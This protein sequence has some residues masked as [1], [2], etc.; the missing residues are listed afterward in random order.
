MRAVAALCPNLGK[1]SKKVAGRI[2]ELPIIK[3]VRGP[4]ATLTT[5]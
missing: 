4:I 3:G 2:R 1:K 5:P